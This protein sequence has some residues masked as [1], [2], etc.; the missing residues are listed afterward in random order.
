MSYFLWLIMQRVLNSE[1]AFIASRWCFR[2]RCS[3]K[4]F[5]S[6]MIWC[7]KLTNKI[8]GTV[9]LWYYF[10]VLCCLVDFWSCIAWMC[11]CLLVVQWFSTAPIVSSHVTMQ[12]STDD[13]LQKP[14]ENKL[15]IS[16]HF[17]TPNSCSVI[18]LNLKLEDAHVMAMM[19]I[20]EKKVKL[21]V[22][23]HW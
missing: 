14:I 15:N 19:F 21:R 18:W 1:N 22:N 7:S 6:D 9:H 13:I 8:L 10:F 20:K 16:R 12:K 3:I 11:V 2:C 5:V 17:L 4:L 23:C